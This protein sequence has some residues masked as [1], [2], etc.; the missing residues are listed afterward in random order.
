MGSSGTVRASHILVKHKDSRRPSSWKEPT[1]TRSKARFAHDGTTS[2][3][4]G[5][6]DGLRMQEEAVTMV[7]DF[8]ER[9][10]SGQAH[11]ADIA[12]KESHC[13]SAKRGGDL[14]EFG[15]GQMQPAFEKATYA[16]KAGH[17]LVSTQNT[18]LLV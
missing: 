5:S 2:E 11:F 3:C 1:V 12:A 17:Y 18:A 10:V 9:I 6:A 15:P 8:R 7:K 4:E 13:S 14:G 16:L